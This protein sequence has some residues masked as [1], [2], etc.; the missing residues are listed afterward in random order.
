MSYNYT[1]LGTTRNAASLLS[2]HQGEKWRII[3]RID[4]Q[5]ENFGP[6]VSGH[7]LVIVDFW[8]V[9]PLSDAS[10][11]HHIRVSVQLGGK[12][13]FELVDTSTPDG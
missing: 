11:A 2:R 6:Y 10:F 5:R 13:H 8:L 3:A 4:N 9:Y 12:R 1:Y 7:S